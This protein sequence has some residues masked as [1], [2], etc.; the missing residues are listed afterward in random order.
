MLAALFPACI[1]APPPPVPGYPPAYNVFGTWYQPIPDA[2]GFSQKGYASWY[3]KKFHGRKTSNGET[4]NMYGLTAAHKT[5]PLGTWLK[6]TNLENGKTVNVRVNDRGPFVK[7]RIIDLSY[8]AAK[9]IDMTLKGT[10]PVRITVIKNKTAPPPSKTVQ[11]DTKQGV[12]YCVQ[13]GSFASRKNAESFMSD[14][15]KSFSNVHVSQVNGTWK[16]RIGKYTSRDRADIIKQ[17]LI[18]DGFS[19]FIVQEP[20]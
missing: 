5:L 2:R 18:Q 11:Q 16:V 6:V 1:S 8:T 4:Y 3:G 13:T 20:I 14:L 7:G 12:H 19:A 15:D 17:Q 10:A 9:T